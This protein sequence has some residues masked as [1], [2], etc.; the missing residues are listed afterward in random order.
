MKA[1]RW[2]EV[3]IRAADFASIVAASRNAHCRLLHPRL[4]SLCCPRRVVV[5]AEGP[6][7]EP[8][9]TDGTRAEIGIGQESHHPE[10]VGPHGGRFETHN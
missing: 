1:F 2:D 7:G 10:K 5:S 9:R 8:G 6:P 4:A 3:A